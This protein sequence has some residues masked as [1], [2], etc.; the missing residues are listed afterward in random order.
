M[1]A[2]VSV[3][4]KTGLVP[5]VQ[6]LQEAGLE[7]YSTGGTGRALEEGGVAVHGISEMTGFPE[8]LEGRVKTL[9]PKVYGG[10]LAV[11]ANEA[12][13]RELAQ[14]GIEPIDVVVVNLYPF[15][16]TVARQDVTMDEALENIDIGGPTLLR[17]GAKNFP[18]VLV[19]V[20]PGDY[21]WVQERLRQGE[22]SLE[23]RR[24]LAQKAFQHVALYDTAIA[25][26]L[27]GDGDPLA[28]ELTIGLTRI[29]SL[30]Y[31]E[32]PHQ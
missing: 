24:G 23:E 1:R 25:R 5:F 11:R 13:L 30:R 15:M 29:Q 9:H 17:A 20:D 21:G 10:L 31:G 14:N 19:V 3:S 2:I 32:N 7:I 28:Q 4:D 8:I 26:Y 12:H 27:R 16:K 18:S 6:G 22:V